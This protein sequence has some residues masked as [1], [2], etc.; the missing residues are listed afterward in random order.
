MHP[1]AFATLAATK[2]T[3]GVYYLATQPAE[4]IATTLFGVPVYLSTHMPTDTIVAAEA[5]RALVIGMRESITVTLNPF[6]DSAWSTGLVEV[7]A[8]MRVAVSVRDPQA[9]QKLTLSGAMAREPMREPGRDEK[10]RAGK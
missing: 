5:A 2:A 3:S 4:A 6:S 7:R 8:V 1:S 9:A 10:P